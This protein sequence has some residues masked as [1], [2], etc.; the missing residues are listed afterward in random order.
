MSNQAIKPFPNAKTAWLFVIGFL[1]GCGAWFRVF[2]IGFF[3][4][5]G[6]SFREA[7]IWW[8][9]AAAIVSAVIAAFQPSARV[10]WS[11]GFAAPIVGWC[12]LCTLFAFGDSR[13]LWWTLVGS[14]TAVTAL[15]GA[16]LGRSVGRRLT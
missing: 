9:A 14:I 7:A 6:E 3:A 15:A 8:F 1:L 2:S 13:Y 11:L 4:S 12:L 10:F 5:T 16:L